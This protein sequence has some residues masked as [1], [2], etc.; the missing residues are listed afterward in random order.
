MSVPTKLWMTRGQ[1]LVLTISS[2]LSV[3]LGVALYEQ[4]KD[5]IAFTHCTARWQNSFSD[6]YIA[7]ANAA[8]EV[9][10]AMDRVITAVGDRDARAFNAA[11]RHYLTVRATQDRQKAQHPLP[12]LPSEVCG[13]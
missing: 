13:R 3:S 10:N 9:S 12:A 6:A 1:A 11:V 7:R 8:T 2:I 4:K 5:S